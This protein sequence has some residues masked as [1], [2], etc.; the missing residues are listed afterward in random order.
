MDLLVVGDATKTVSRLAPGSVDLTVMSPPYDGVRDYGGDYNPRLPMLG[1]ALYEATAE[2][3]IA[4]VVIGDGTIDGAK[5]LTTFS[6]ALAWAEC[7][8][9]LFE[10]CI[11][12]RHGKPGAWW[13][14]RFRVDHEFILIFVKG[15]RPKSFDKEPL[16]VP[17]KH[18]GKTW[19]GT[20][21][22]TDGSLSAIKQTEQAAMKCRGTVW[23]YATSNTEGNKPKMEHPATF[24]DALAGDLI[25]CFS[26][27]GDL[28]LDP[29]CGSGTTVVTALNAGR[30]ALGVDVNADYIDLA[31][32]RVAAETDHELVCS[33]CG[34]DTA[35]VGLFCLDCADEMHNDILRV[36]AEARHGG[37]GPE[38]D[39]ER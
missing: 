33:E 32:R 7:G 28:V 12:E 36:V 22:H 18:A 14:K 1:A 31:W 39:A 17:A 16:M 10:T 19:G 13:S 27:P 3:G 2:G 30:R 25:A 6:L 23:H 24:P 8:W 9:R 15:Q 34:N 37:D 21:R 35:T 29:M 11:Y 38:K 26:S 4:A 5:S 20:Q